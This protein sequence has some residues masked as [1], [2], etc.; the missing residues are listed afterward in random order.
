MLF[1][2]SLH[3]QADGPQIENKQFLCLPTM[4]VQEFEQENVA[5][6]NENLW[7]GSSSITLRVPSS[8]KLQS[9]P[10]SPTLQRCKSF[11]KLA[12]NAADVNIGNVLTVQSPKLKRA[13]ARTAVVDQS[14][15]KMQKSFKTE[16]LAMQEVKQDITPKEKETVSVNRTP[17]LL[18]TPTSP[19]LQ[20][21][22]STCSP[23]LQRRGTSPW[24]NKFLNNDT[25]V[26]KSKVFTMP[27]SPKLKT[28]VTRAAK[29]E[30]SNAKTQKV[31][32]TENLKKFEKEI[33]SEVKEAPCIDHDCARV[34][35]TTPS[36]PRLQSNRSSPVLQ[37]GRSVSYSSKLP[38]NASYSDNS[39]VFTAPRSPILK[40]VEAKAPKGDSYGKELKALQAE[41]IGCRRTKML[42]KGRSLSMPLPQRPAKKDLTLDKN[43]PGIETELQ[44]EQGSS[45]KTGFA[46]MRNLLSI[47]VNQFQPKHLLSVDHVPFQ[48]S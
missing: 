25:D 44:E 20:S 33:I 34:L 21:N 10:G 41:K 19:K 46:D 42:N 15:G 23:I 37:R 1:R 29:A 17:V 35:L 6:K 39:S 28:L 9:N 36:S 45:R 11:A 5:E 27:R 4:S 13:D 22:R 3:L 24:L 43:D 38:Y 14:G 8:P 31:E 18:K 7:L 40:R 30:Q 12:K 32:Q 2:R 26:N 48:Q 47:P 16:N